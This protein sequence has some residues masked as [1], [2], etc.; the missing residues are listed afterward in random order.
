M[1]SITSHNTIE[2]LQ[3]LFSSYSLPEELVSDNGPQLVSKV[4]SSWREMVSNTL[5][6]RRT[7][8]SA[9]NGA[10]QRSAQILKQAQ[11]KDVLEVEGKA[12]L[13]LSQRLASFLLMYSSTPH[14][15]TGRTPAT[16]FLKRHIRTRFS[17]LKPELARR[18]EEKQAAQKHYHDHGSSAVRFFLE[19]ETV[20][21]PKFQGR[22]GEMD[23]GKSA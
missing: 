22:S 18:V 7:D 8:L 20:H 1:T 10:A 15:V 5:L 4:V 23:S 9:S 11:M 6:Y 19:G 17:L 12:S 3:G 21:I 13:P 14:T 16:L 2:V